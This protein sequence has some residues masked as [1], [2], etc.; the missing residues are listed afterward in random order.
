MDVN[1]EQSLAGMDVNGEQLLAEMDVNGEQSLAEMDVNGEQ[2]LAEMDVNGEQSLAEMDVNGEQSLAEMDVN[3]EQSLAGNNAILN[4]LL[5]HAN[6]MHFLMESNNQTHEDIRIT[7]LIIKSHPLSNWGIQTNAIYIREKFNY[8]QK[9]RPRQR[10]ESTPH[11]SPHLETP[12]TSHLKEPVVFPL[13]EDENIENPDEGL[14][15][16]SL[17]LPDTT[18]LKSYMCRMLDFIKMGN[19]SVYLSQLNDV[20][21]FN[22]GLSFLGRVLKNTNLTSLALGENHLTSELL[23]D[24]A[25]HLPESHINSL[26]LSYNFDLNTKLGKDRMNFLATILKDTKITNLNLAGNG[27]NLKLLAPSLKGTKMKSL[28][29]TGCG[30]QDDDF[31]FLADVLKDTQITTLD[32]SDNCLKC[33]SL[34]ILAPCLVNTKIIS[35]SLQNNILIGINGLNCLAA[36]LKDTQITSLDISLIELNSE[37]IK[38]LTLSLV[39][40]K[41]TT[42][43]FSSNYLCSDGLKY[44]SQFLKDTQIT[45]IDVSNF[46]SEDNTAV[47]MFFNSLVGTKIISLSLT[48]CHENMPTLDSL[49]NVLKDTPLTSLKISVTSPMIDDDDNNWMSSVAQCLADSNI[50]SLYLDGLSGS[51]IKCLAEVL[52]ST[53]T[54]S[55]DIRGIEHHHDSLKLLKVCLLNANITHLCWKCD[56]IILSDDLENTDNTY[57]NSFGKLLQNS[58]VT[59]IDLSD[60]DMYGGSMRLLAPSMVYSKLSSLNLSNNCLGPDGIQSLVSV[61]GST[62]ITSLSLARNYL[63]CDSIMNLV[64]SLPKT[65]IT[66][67]NISINTICCSAFYLASVLEKTKLTSL[68]LSNGYFCGDNAHLNVSK[69]SH[70]SDNSLNLSGFRLCS[71]KIFSLCKQL[72]VVNITSLNLSNVCMNCDS[73][74]YLSLGLAGSQIDSLDLSWNSIGWAGALHLARNLVST[75]IS[76]LTLEKNNINCKGLKYLAQGLLGSHVT[77]LNVS[78]NCIGDEGVRYLAK[79][80]VDTQISHLYLFSNNITCRGAFYLSQVLAQIFWLNVSSNRIGCDGVKYLAHGLRGSR[81][82]LLNLASNLIGDEEVEYLS[83]YLKITTTQMDELDLRGNQISPQVAHQVCTSVLQCNHNT[84]VIVDFKNI[85]ENPPMN[86]DVPF[87]SQWKTYF[88]NDE[89]LNLFRYPGCSIEINHAFW[90]NKKIENLIKFANYR[91]TGISNLILLEISSQFSG[92]FDN[93]YITEIEVNGNFGNSSIVP[94]LFQKSKVLGIEIKNCRKST[95][96]LVTQLTV[97]SVQLSYI[98][99]E[100]IL[101]DLSKIID[102]RKSTFC[103]IM[104][105]DLRNNNLGES[106]N[107]IEY[108]AKTLADSL[109]ISLNLSHNKLV[110]EDMSLL[111]QVLPQTRINYIDLYANNIK[112]MGFKC[113]M[114]VVEKTRICWISLAENG[115]ENGLV[116]NINLS[117][118]IVPRNDTPIEF[119]IRYLFKHL[120]SFNTDNQLEF[121]VPGDES[122]LSIIHYPLL[123]KHLLETPSLKIHVYDIFYMLTRRHDIHIFNKTDDF[124]Q[125]IIE[126]FLSFFLNNLPKLVERFGYESFV[127]LVKECEDLGLIEIVRDLLVHRPLYFVNNEQTILHPFI[128]K[129]LHKYGMTIYHKDIEPN[130]KQQIISFFENHLDLYCAQEIIKILNCY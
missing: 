103:N 88:N 66:F 31:K 71:F 112:Y 25:K 115:I 128:Y 22:Y 78:S 44:L 85:M 23:N 101:R 16:T 90:H 80:L 18:L 59:S 77:S 58:Q 5:S 98:E 27:L 92:L 68:D 41:I 14:W 106:E 39:D 127:D 81:M 116:E 4:G 96:E 119:Q 61:L 75:K 6:V 93:I 100:I 33:D 120:V 50:T 47:S 67:L 26:D 19:E 8:S 82:W 38:T 118:Y 110:E 51:D 108:L 36:V 43:K 74:N 24:F 35:L 17:E 72:S 102:G 11:C 107:G 121:I 109:V 40:T 76:K 86:Q 15:S 129:M 104:Y 114:D 111:A 125:E 60:N 83:E 97:I 113:L 46:G 45:S 32:L 89:R 95:L 63:D 30:I 65:K 105:L 53:K 62:Q 122:M 124:I 13:N 9:S 3:G 79:H 49:A 48:Y 84:T 21:M 73:M 20:I 10:T 34:M 57:E 126:R 42:L 52:M 130:K 123:I 54:T 29:L 37:F 7:C 28:D 99:E 56:S 2:S 87:S 70:F 69:S 94:I 117:P 64:M 12:T 91:K 1:G 55:I